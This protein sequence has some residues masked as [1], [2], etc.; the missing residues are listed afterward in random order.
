MFS[1]NATAPLCD[2]LDKTG[3]LSYAHGVQTVRIEI[4]AL[5]RR[6]FDCATPSFRHLLLFN[7]RGKLEAIK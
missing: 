1:V 6:V 7:L 4:G 3:I 5:D 2:P